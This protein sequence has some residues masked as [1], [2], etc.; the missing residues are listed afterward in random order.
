M[1]RWPSPL[2][3][4]GSLD[5]QALK[6]MREQLGITRTQHAKEIGV[7]RNTLM[8]WEDGSKLPHHGATIQ[9]ALSWWRKAC[10]KLEARERKART[11]M[12]SAGPACGRPVPPPES[13]PE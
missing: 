9:S 4:D 12:Q 13:T 6:L 3:S 11:E 10:L 7:T 2:T 5:P 8:H 1:S